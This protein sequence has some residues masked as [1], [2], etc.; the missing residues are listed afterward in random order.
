[1]S[2]ESFK[3]LSHNFYANMT[4]G[5]FNPFL[6]RRI[7][8]EYQKL[9]AQELVN[10]HTFIK[11]I[12]PSLT[13]LHFLRDETIDDV[14][15][16]YESLY[17]FVVRVKRD[18]IGFAARTGKTVIMNDFD[19]AAFDGKVSILVAY[20]LGKKLCEREHTADAPAPQRAAP[21]LAQLS[22]T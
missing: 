15:G 6:S 16:F 12:D 22:L 11:K 19:R 14:L 21:T 17:A 2:A 10:I 20:D 4:D 8:N 7:E 1:M 3:K 5:N 13:R 18:N 9:S